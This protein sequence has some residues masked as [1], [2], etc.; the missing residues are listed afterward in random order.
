MKKTFWM[1]PSS[2]PPATQGGEGGGPRWY[3]GGCPPPRGQARPPKEAARSRVAA[4]CEKRGD[5][6]FER[7]VGPRVWPA[8]PPLHHGWTH[9]RRHSR[10]TRHVHGYVHGGVHRRWNGGREAAEAAAVA[11]GEERA[12]EYVYRHAHVH[13]SHD[14]RTCAASS[15][16][17]IKKRTDP[18]IKSTT[19]EDTRYY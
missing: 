6:Y 13:S 1:V 4:D 8:R 10:T 5:G 2:N 15:C 9:T 11:G 7:K 17:L 3:S 12:D 14:T 19:N 18:S 16:V